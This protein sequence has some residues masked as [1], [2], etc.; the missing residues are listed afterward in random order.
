MYP[1]LEEYVSSLPEGLDSYGRCQAKASMLRTALQ[2]GGL[3]APQQG[4]PAPLRDLFEAPPAVTAWIPE[5]VSVAAHLAVA[6]ENGLSD[7]AL[8]DW[9]YQTNRQLAH[10]RLYR[11][12]ASLASPDLVLRVARTSWKVLHRGIDLAVQ[13]DNHR[14]ELSVTHPGGVWNRLVHLA[15]ATGFR[16]VLESSRGK[17]VSVNLAES[18][19]DGATYNCAWT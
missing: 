11:A 14:A 1:R 15:T 2:T 4:L 13:R 7:E 19:A 18:R 12:V 8:L 3:R 16:A 9:T 17:N 6:D 5:A 10:S